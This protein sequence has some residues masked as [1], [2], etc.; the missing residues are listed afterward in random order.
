MDREIFLLDSNSLITPYLQY[1]P[2]DLA[3]GFWT[4]IEKHIEDGDIA[5]L[6]LVKKEILNGHDGLKDWIGGLSVDII[7]RRDPDIIR[8]YG[9]VLQCV[10]DDPR[11]KQAALMEWSRGDIADPWLIATAKVKGHTII[12]FEKSV[13][14]T[15]DSPSK[16]AKIPDIAACFDVVVHDLFYMMRELHFK[17]K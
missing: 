16:N 3:P 17:L 6:D 10:Q 8:V 14:T 13:K 11:Y 7:D 12:T 9:D 15:V 1:Y 2:F 4:Q 5:I